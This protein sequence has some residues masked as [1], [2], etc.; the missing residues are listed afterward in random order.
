MQAPSQIAQVCGG[1]FNMVENISDE[2]GCAEN[3][4]NENDVESISTSRT[5]A[6]KNGYFVLDVHP[7]IH[8]LASLLLGSAL[9]IKIR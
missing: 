5:Y 1:G 8:G 6:R 4:E 7:T 3:I 2:Y 9:K